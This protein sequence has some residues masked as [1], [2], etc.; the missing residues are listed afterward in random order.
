MSSCC[1]CRPIAT[2]RPLEKRAALASQRGSIVRRCLRWSFEATKWLVPG[3]AL[4]LM[5]KCPVCLAA[6]VALATGL[7]ISLPAAAWVRTLLIVLCIAS[8]GYLG[9]RRLGQVVSRL[10]ARR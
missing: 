3:A 6:Y 10:A 9:Y 5:P 4:A 8:L 7:G 1:H 2:A